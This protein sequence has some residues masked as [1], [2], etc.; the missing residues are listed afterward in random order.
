MRGERASGPC[1]GE[2]AVSAEEGPVIPAEEEQRTQQGEG[3][4]GP[5]GE[6]QPSWLVRDCPPSGGGT[7]VHATEKLRTRQGCCAQNREGTAVPTEEEQ[8]SQPERG[9]QSRRGRG[10]TVPAEKPWSRRWRDGG[11]VR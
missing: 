7:A 4:S 2:M 11:P 1:P 5:S 3:D 9:Q 6:E 10:T 8:S